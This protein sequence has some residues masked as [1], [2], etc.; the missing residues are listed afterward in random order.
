MAL[1]MISGVEFALALLFQLGMGI[2]KACLVTSDFSCR[3]SALM[4]LWSSRL[5]SLSSRRLKS[6]A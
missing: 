5:R 2:S 3:D 6:P 4:A 1:P